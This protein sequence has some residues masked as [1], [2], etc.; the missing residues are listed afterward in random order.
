MLILNTAELIEM[1]FMDDKAPR[2]LISMLEGQ[3]P[4]FVMSDLAANTTGH[5]STDHLKTVALVEADIAIAAYA[6]SGAP[7]GLLS[8]R[9]V[10]K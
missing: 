2:K 8:G 3:K 5:R 9:A 1:D 10:I 6:T 7:K 4:D